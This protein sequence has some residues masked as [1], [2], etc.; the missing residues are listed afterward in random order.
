MLIDVLS[1]HDHTSCP[2][3]AIVTHT[4]NDGEFV[5]GFGLVFIGFDFIDQMILES[6]GI[7]VDIS[8]PKIPL[9]KIGSV[10]V[11]TPPVK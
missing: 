1:T 3:D 9:V 6:K 8:D 11:W 5:L 2:K 10:L 7:K 4:L